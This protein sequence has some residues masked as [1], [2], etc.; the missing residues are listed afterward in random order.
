MKNW[1]TG[2]A[3]DAG[4][5]W[6]QEEKGTTGDEIVGWH[7]RL[8]G[9]EFDQAPGVGDGQGSLTCCSPWGRKELDTPDQLNWTECTPFYI[10]SYTAFSRVDL[11]SFHQDPSVEYL[12]DFYFLLYFYC[13]EWHCGWWCVYLCTEHV[14]RA[15]VQPQLIQGIR[16][17]DGVG[18]G[19]GTTA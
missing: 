18:E 19:Q 4:K 6:R 13:Y 10:V 7:H 11:C 8:D 3:P 14:L 2:K 12:G 9:H 17:R 5:D 15:G 1:H 16:S